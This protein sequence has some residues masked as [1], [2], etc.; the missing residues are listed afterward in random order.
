[1]SVDVVIPTHNRVELLVEA[2]ESAQ[3]QSM[4]PDTIFIVSDIHCPEAESFLKE[5]PANAVK[6]QYIWWE[7]SED[8]PASGRAPISRNLGIARSQADWIA[9]LDDD[10]HWDQN[11]LKRQPR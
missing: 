3:S 9:M 7:A 5:R 8:I 2:L 6:V 1:M 11:Y 10:D 4:R